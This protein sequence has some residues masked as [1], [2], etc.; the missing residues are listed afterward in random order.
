M[1]K[2][3]NVIEIEIDG[4]RNQSHYF[5]PLQQKIRG[6]FDPTR[7]QKFDDGAG[8]IAR[9]WPQPIPGQRL[10]LNPTDGTA[11]IVDPLHEDEHADTRE[12]IERKGYRLPV[13]MKTFEAVHVPTWA[14]WMRSA[15]DAGCARVLRGELPDEIDGEPQTSFVVTRRKDPMERLA[16]AIEKQNE[17][18]LQLLK[19]K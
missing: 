1:A 7:L 17:L 8:K 3:S 4:E 9:E 10:R 13:A 15:V 12:R 19:A 2:A 11:A 16:E 14:Y 6:R 18:M 5:R